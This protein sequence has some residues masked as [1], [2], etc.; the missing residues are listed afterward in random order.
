MEIF[1]AGL[2]EMSSSEYLALPCVNQSYLKLF[3][4]SA[5]HALTA[6]YS[7]PTSDQIF[8]TQF[9]TLLLENEKFDQLYVRE[10]VYIINGRKAEGKAEREAAKAIIGDRETI[11]A[12][13]WIMLNK[14]H[15]ETTTDETA[16]AL[17]NEGTAEQT[18]I[19]EDELGFW[20]KARID[21]L[22]TGITNLL[23]DVKTT[24]SANPKDLQR[25][26]V[27]WGYHLQEAF[28]IRGWRH[29]FGVE[30]DFV[31]SFHE[32]PR[33]PEDRPIPPVL[34]EL[35]RQFRMAGE[36]EI[37]RLMQL[38]Q[39]CT[40][41]GYWPSYTKGITLLSPPPWFKE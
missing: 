41:S 37:V 38:H 3:K 10:P 18:L 31:F 33:D 25:G 17:F 26:V 24:R 13:H 16:A 27:D 23:V 2:F 20:C 1:K 4:K 11:S 29:V 7:K 40:A 15:E 6:R 9:H 12:D 32:K 22:P 39:Q 34:I 35:D 30:P 19:W 21:W 5:F 28:Y 8:G 36:R 14:M